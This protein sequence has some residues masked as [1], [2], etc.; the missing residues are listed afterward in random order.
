MNIVVNIAIYDIKWIYTYMDATYSPL[1]NRMD[2]SDYTM[3]Q[4]SII[5]QEFV[6]K[7]NIKVK[8]HN[9]YIFTQVTKG[10]NGLP[11]SGQ[12]SHDALV[13]NLEHYGYRPLRKTLA[14]WTHGRRTINFTLIVDDFGVKYLVK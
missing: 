9:C 4:I 5:Q 11:Q 8:E 3:I 13:K 7:Y 1:N 6:D 2:R 10:E 12:I 14:L